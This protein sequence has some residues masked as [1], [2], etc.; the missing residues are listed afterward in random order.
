MVWP[1]LIAAGGSLA[2]G[3][4]ANAASARQARMQ[5]A[6]QER[7]S[8]TAHQREV[9]DLRAAGLNPIL[10]ATGGSG[11]SS[12]GGAMAMQHDVVT[13]A[14]STALSSLRNRAEV[15]AIEA[16]ARK[17]GLEADAIEAML[18][19]KQVIRDVVTS[20]RDLVEKVTA[21]AQRKLTDF[22]EW[23]ANTKQGL[24]SDA[25]SALRGLTLEELLA[26]RPAE[27]YG[28]PLPEDLKGVLKA[29]SAEDVK[30]VWR[31]LQEAFKRAGTNPHYKP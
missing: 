25:H 21:P 18:P 5:M 2:G 10:S 26:E 12:P 13:P 31:E 6:F 4:M 15:K 9:A 29:F 27:Q 22:F 20:G 7:M 19:G 17:T 8:S 30:R 11:A 3:S 24:R 14:V 28:K 1:A 23:M 16:S